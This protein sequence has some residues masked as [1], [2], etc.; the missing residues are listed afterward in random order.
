LNEDF[1]NTSAA[2]GHLMATLAYFLLSLA[3]LLLKNNY[4]FL[5]GQLSRVDIF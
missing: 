1:L 5:W 3:V 2:D 4:E